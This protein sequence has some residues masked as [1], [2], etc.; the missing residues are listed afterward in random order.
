MHEIFMRMAL[1]EAAAAMAEDEVPIGAIIV[2]EGRVI[3]R[4]TT[5][6]NSFAIPRPTRR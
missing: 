3:A 1:E 4:R 5:S 2:H 6:A